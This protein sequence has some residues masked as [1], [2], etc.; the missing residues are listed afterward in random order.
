MGEEVRLE[1]ARL[2]NMGTNMK[3]GVPGGYPEFGNRSPILIKP[4]IL[5]TCP[6][7]VESF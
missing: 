1:G 3:R 6:V 5:S 2:R 7:F 4:L